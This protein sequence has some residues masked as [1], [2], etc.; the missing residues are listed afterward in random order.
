MEYE[1]LLELAKSRRTI[2]A[3]KPDPVP[4]EMIDKM[5]DLA[6]WAPT[7]FNLQPAEFLVVEDSNLRQAVK[8][9]V[10]EW[11]ENDFYALEATREEW[12]GPPW[13]LETRGRVGCPLAPVYIFVLGDTRRRAGLPMNAR[14]ERQKGDSIFES[15][16]SNAFLYL[17]LAAQSLGLGAQPVSVVKNGRVQGLVKHLLNLPD[18]IYVYEL[19]VVGYGAKEGGP[20]AKLMRHLDE[21]V[22]RGR[23]RDDEFQSEEE[24]RKQIRKL[25]MG[26]VARHEEAEKKS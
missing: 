14:Y 21:V 25:R 9:I 15:S 18:F 8:K 16:L 22:H 4:A 23:A 26:N 19:L 1:E 12:Q 13:T 7:G 3:L 5:L 2:R 10:D 11:I 24:L 6:R 17:W 20:P